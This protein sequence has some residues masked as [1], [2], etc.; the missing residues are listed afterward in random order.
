MKKKYF[1]DRFWLFGFGCATTRAAYHPQSQPQLTP[2]EV[3]PRGGLLIIV[4][5]ALV[6]I[7]LIIPFFK[8]NKAKRKKKKCSS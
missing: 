1:L 8:N 5:V 7:S 3:T 6:M 2:I 4:L